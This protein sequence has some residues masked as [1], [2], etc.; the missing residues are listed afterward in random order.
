M[1]KKQKIHVMLQELY[2]KH[3]GFDWD[4]YWS[5]FEKRM[6]HNWG[7]RWKAI[8]KDKYSKTLTQIK[9]GEK[10]D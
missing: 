4:I 10:D 5:E 1:N 2:E 7:G 9:N 3:C 8:G 6:E